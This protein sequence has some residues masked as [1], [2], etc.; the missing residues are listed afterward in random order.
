VKFFRCRLPADEA[1]GAVLASLQHA[2][3]LCA[4]HVLRIPGGQIAV[5]LQR[6]IDALRAASIPVEVLEDLSLRGPPSTAIP[7]DI[8]TGF[9]SSYLDAAQVAA[10]FAALQAAFPALAQWTALPEATSGYDGS[11]TSL[12]GP[13]TVRML[14]INTTPA[15]LA[16]PGLLVIAGLHAREWAPPLAALE[17]ASQ[18]LRNYSPGSSDPAVQA[19]N[20]LVDGLDILIVPGANPDGINYSHHDVPLWRKNRRPNPPM[21]SCPGADCNRNFSIYFGQAGSSSD[22][23]DFQ[24]YHGPSAFSEPEDRNLRSIL[25]QYPNILTAIDCHSFGENL[26]RPQPTGGTFISSEPIE[27]ADDSIYRSLESA[28]NAAIGSVTP[29]KVYGT[30]TTSNHAGTCDEYCFFGHRVYGFELEIGQDFQPP[31]ADALVSVQEAAAAMRAAGAQT[32]S[33]GALFTS[34][35]SLVQVIDKSGS[36]ISFG[37]AD[38]ARA[39]AAR[40]VDLMRLGDSAGIVSFNGAATLERARAPI[41]APGDYASVRAAAQGIAF[42]GSTSIGAGLQMAAA[43]MTGTVA[44]RGIVLLSDGFENT[45]PMVS[46]VLPTLPAGLKVHTI[47]LGPAS[48]QALLQNIAAATG[49]TFF[50]SPDEL[51][52]FELYDLVRADA[53]DD[54]VAFTDT[55]ATPGDAAASRSVVIEDGVLHASFSVASLRAGVQVTASLVAPAGTGQDLSRVRSV[56]GDG[57]C[58]LR[59]RRPQAGTWTLRV[60]TSEAASVAATASV[61]APLRL[62]L[63]VPHLVALHEPLAI[64]VGVHLAEEPLVRLRA[65]TQVVAPLIAPDRLLRDWKGGPLPVPKPLLSSPDALPHEAVQALLIREQRLTDGEKDPLRSVSLRPTRHALHERSRLSHLTALA[66]A[67]TAGSYNIRV[68]VEGQTPSGAPFGRQAIR[69]V[70]VGAA[71]PR[72]SHAG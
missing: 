56:Q 13:A 59:V 26:F 5:L 47:A 57:Y 52:L 19:L 40:L 1:S 6:E 2:G 31:L 33:L 23:C 45:S 30:G 42:G 12:A 9:V 8:A 54:D 3:E 39:N 66:A 36:M 37:Y 68:R 51:Q 63:Q 69:S 44:P 11:A 38:A 10:G 71:V 48:D 49:G 16:K 14:R 43:Q 25:E 21:L 62:R 4:D 58:I 65:V 29:A 72:T 24:I 46:T 22:P 15:S 70:R 41:A 60:R 55:F 34:P 28:M 7:D 18:L 67:R 17:F 32:L 61:R 20:A 50:Y 64:G 35:T 27:P 53:T